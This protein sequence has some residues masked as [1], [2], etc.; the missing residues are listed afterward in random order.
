[1]LGFE[2]M[3]TDSHPLTPAVLAG[4]RRA[5]ARAITLVESEGATAAAAIVKGVYRRSGRACLIGVTGSPGVGKSTLVDRITAA[6]RAGDR[7]VGVLAVDP[8]SPFTGGAILGDRVRMQTHA[9]DPGVFVRSMATRGEFGGLARATG[10]AAVILDAAGFDVVI[11]DTVGVGQAEVEVAR[12]ADMSI[13]VTMPGAG[14]GVQALKAGVMEIGDLFVVNKADRG[15][16]D[17]AVAEIEMMLGF[18][19][20]GPDDWRPPVLSTRAIDGSGVDALLDT[21]E[22]FRARGGELALGRRRAR[23]Q[24]TI[25][26]LVANRFL[27][28]S[29]RHGFESDDF[30]RLVDRVVNVELD[31]YSAAEQ[32]LAWNGQG[33]G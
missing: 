12:A 27:Q 20:Y 13:V 3:N 26:R 28:D 1:V 30:T 31:P 16:S 14:D 21:V 25:R 15:G 9:G 10:D 8:T 17:R 19:D 5:I 32:T 33:K 23:V 6:Y 24:A 7:T 22:R 29:E 11:I 4:D 2:E 18:N